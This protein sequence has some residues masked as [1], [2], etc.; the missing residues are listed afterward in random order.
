ML[1]GILLSK[2]PCKAK[3]LSGGT[4]QSESPSETGY[5]KKPT[6]T[7]T[8]EHKR[9]RIQNERSGNIEAFISNFFWIGFMFA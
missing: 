4:N 9:A 7:R 6:I 2:C 5:I 3:D 1:S 8:A